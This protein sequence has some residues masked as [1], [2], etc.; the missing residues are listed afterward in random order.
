MQMNFRRFLL[1]G[2]ISLF[3]FSTAILEARQ[4]DALPQQHPTTEG[5]GARMRFPLERTL[6]P[7]SHAEGILGRYFPNLHGNE[8]IHFDY[9]YTGG[10]FTNARGGARARGATAY[11]GIMDIGITADTEKLGLWKNGTFYMHSLFSHGPSPSRYIEDY[12]GVSV[13]AYETPAQVSEYWYEHRFFD[14]IFMLKGGKQDAGT[15]FF[16]LESTSDFINSSATCVPTTGIPTAPD[17]AWGLAGS[18]SLGERI[19]LKA[20]I[21]DARGNAGKFWMSESGEVYSAFQVEYR[22]SLFRRLSGFAYFGGWYDN[23]DFEEYGVLDEDGEFTRTRA[24]NYGFNAGFEQM[25]YRRNPRNCKDLRGFTIFFQY[26]NAKK[27]RNELDSAWTFGVHWLG[28]FDDRK[29]DCMGFAVNTVRFDEGFRASEALRY[30]RETAYEVFY[31]A[32][33]TEN[34]S[35]QPLLQYVVH[36]GGEHR[37][38]FVPGFVFQVVF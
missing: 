4:T 3:L 20:G 22:Y 19:G 31:K 12:Q 36:P 14:G 18:L 34:F 11:N 16:F 15:D 7:S 25:V 23:G 5:A 24:G 37:N 17:N 10:V 1:I 38:S 2:G 27:N 9:I 33:I 13:F 26:G 21:Y 32:Q 29:E 35:V 6:I 28:P 30:G 8:A